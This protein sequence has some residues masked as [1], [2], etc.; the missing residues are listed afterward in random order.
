MYRIGDKSVAVTSA[1]GKWSAMST[2]Q[3][4]VPEPTSRIR[5]GDVMGARKSLSCRVRS[6]RWCTMDLQ[7]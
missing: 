7:N 2:A 6:Q 1:P 4:P 5:L 3:R